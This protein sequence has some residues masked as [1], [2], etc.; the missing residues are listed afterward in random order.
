MKKIFLS[1]LCL[2]LALGLTTGCE[3]NNND[4]NKT[5]ENN[6]QTNSSKE[7]EVYDKNK[8]GQLVSDVSITYN[9]K[10][11]KFPFTVN[12]LIDMGFK[13]RY[14]TDKTKTIEPNSF[15]V[16]GDSLLLSNGNKGIHVI[17]Y[18]TSDKTVSFGDCYVSSLTASSDQI[19]INGITPTK[20]SYED[21]LEKFG[22]EN[23]SRK[24]T[25]KEEQ[26]VCYSEMRTLDMQYWADG[27]KTYVGN[28]Y[29][30]SLGFKVV[31]DDTTGK[32]KSVQ[33]DWLD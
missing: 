11:L 26:E 2:G 28:R 25:F 23:S 14:E 7:Y 1:I 33:I 8:D 5:N 6:A 13:Y 4:N 18:N 20:Q 21:I 24:N 27:S 29:V 22:K 32:V 17:A 30:D 3:K 15:N 9:G 12:D 31:I 19:T 10:T 16:G